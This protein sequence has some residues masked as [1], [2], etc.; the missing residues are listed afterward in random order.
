MVAQL[1][2]GTFLDYVNVRTAAEIE[3]DAKTMPDVKVGSQ[4]KQRTIQPVGHDVGVNRLVRGTRN[5]AG[6][7]VVKDL[8]SVGR[9]N[10][11]LNGH[12]DGPPPKALPEL[13]VPRA[14]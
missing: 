9:E 7:C 11:F 6:T 4:A 2:L 5:S 13:D 12:V 10:A 8:L 3:I 1:V 14:E